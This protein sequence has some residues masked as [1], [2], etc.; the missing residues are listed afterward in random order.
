MLIM[1]FFIF[2]VCLFEFICGVVYEVFFDIEKRKQYD[3]IGDEKGQ[4][5]GGGFL[6]GYGG[7][8]FGG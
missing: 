8:N 4:G 6:G 2:C 3:L 7:G 5:F 1:Y